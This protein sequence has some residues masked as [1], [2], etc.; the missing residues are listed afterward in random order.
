MLRLHRAAWGDAEDFGP[1]T[2]SRA[3]E[4]A[5]GIKRLEELNDILGRTFN[6]HHDPRI[7]EGRKRKYRNLVQEMKRL[8]IRVPK[9]LHPELKDETIKAL[10][11]YGG[12]E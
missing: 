11:G 6:A 1:K 8:M 2:I 5:D 4:I 3:E 9:F 7:M 12:W 10:R